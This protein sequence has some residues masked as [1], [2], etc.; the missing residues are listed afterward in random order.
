MSPP[1]DQYTE[2]R[3]HQ[4]GEDRNKELEGFGK[5]DVEV[6]AQISIHAL[7]A[8][9][10]YR[11]FE[12]LASTVDPNG[13]HI[14][15]PLDIKK[16]PSQLGHDR[17]IVVCI[18][19]SPGRNHL[20]Q[21][22]DY[23]PAWYNLHMVEDNLCGV[24]TE[25]FVA[26]PMSLQTFLDF[27]IGAA[28]C[29]EMLHSQQI[30]HGEIR[31]DSFHM[32]KETGKIR[33]VNLGSGPRTFEHALSSTG[34]STISKELGA[35]T[36]LSYMSPE[37]TGRMPMEP[38]SRT[39]VYSLGV[40]FRMTLLRKSAS[41]GETPM[42]IIQAVLGQQ[43]PSVSST[44]HDIPD[45]IGRIIQKATAKAVS[46]RYQSA[47][48]LRHDLGEVRRLLQ[49]GDSAQLMNWEIARKDVCPFFNLPDLMVGR[50]AEHDAI[51]EA[52]D[53][54]F[55]LRQ[56]SQS[57]SKQVINH[58]SRL[59]EGRF[60]SF[61]VAFTADIAFLGDDTTSSV[62]DASNSL[63]A[64]DVT[65]ENLGAFKPNTGRLRSP[66]AS[67]RNPLD[68]PGFS[69][70]DS[71]PKSPEK[72]NS[73]IPESMSVVESIGEGSGS[74]SSSDAVESMILHRSKG[75]IRTKGRCE[76]ITIAGA[77]GLG[78]S[79]LIQ[80]VQVEARR[81]GYFASSKFDQA[82]KTPFGPVL[83]LLS[84]LFKQSFSES[85][86][87]PVLHH[88]LKQHVEPVWP[89]LHK[90]LSLP[91]FLLGPE[92]P[93][94]VASQTATLST[95]YQKNLVADLGSRDPSP[96]LSQTKLYSKTLG[97]QSSWDFLREGA[98]AK[99]PP[100]MN[101]FL[102]ILRIFTQQKFVCFCLDDLHLADE[103]S[104]ELLAQIISTRINMVLIVAYRPESISSEK[105]R[106][107]LHLSQNDGISP[108]C[109]GKLHQ[110]LTKT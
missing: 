82:V 103:E 4:S 90:V 92:L 29:I 44:R 53:S 26:E 89:T 41:E 12:T 11:A 14:V 33:L 38:D 85:S 78:K 19:E 87:D 96:S 36:K 32:N 74:I 34:W 83:K 24:H 77:A 60:A 63:S 39:D 66:A 42:D 15:Q 56:A 45:V 8:E 73:T 59:S 67:Q 25:N 1:Y 106:R 91:K 99:S 46:E 88:S 40:L 68:S 75:S 35:K 64:S 62:D 109:N 49:T 54:A 102:D 86:M 107:I 52:I 28:E 80:S 95:G 51:V 20:S 79:R 58:P 7:R 5:A 6:V 16:F 84:S 23:G 9:R 101:T 13:Y 108:A 55:K 37:Q 18:F 70:S 17:P 47:S 94:R 98:S 30:V 105:L 21:F 93:A 27:S 3:T 69:A 43:F 97:A 57:R 10:A 65:A 2:R 76:V 81:R 31:G 110:M 100:L 48:G 61:D 71:G 50:S 22:I 104:L 72:R